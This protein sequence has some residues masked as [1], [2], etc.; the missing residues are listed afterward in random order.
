[1]LF[2][3]ILVAYDNSEQS[4]R[5]LYMAMEFAKADRTIKVDVITVLNT[6]TPVNYGYNIVDFD[7]IQKGYY[8]RAEEIF[9]E[10]KGICA[11]IENQLETHIEE[12]TPA[13]TIISFA[14]ERGSD[15]I[16]IGSR[17]L[18]TFSELVLGS[19]SHNVTQHSLV[20]VLIVK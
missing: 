8:A 11:S 16:L 14:K 18:G 2:S 3:K 5:A 6:P 20:N 7:G 15:L 13:F 4:K 10:V 12:G 9:T 17:G 19:V 1:M